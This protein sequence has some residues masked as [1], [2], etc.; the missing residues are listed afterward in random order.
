V[1]CF[2]VQKEIDC[3]PKTN[4]SLSYT[5]V[6]LRRWGLK[7]ETYNE[8]LQQTNFLLPVVVTNFGRNICEALLEDRAVRNKNSIISPFSIHLVMSMLYYG[9]KKPSSTRDQLHNA[10]GSQVDRET[11]TKSAWHY[12]KLLQMYK[13]EKEALGLQTEI[14]N[15]IFVKE[16][17]EVKQL[18]KEVL[19]FYL[20]SSENIDFENP[21]LAASEINQFVSTKTKGLIDKIISPSNIDSLTRL[22]LV[23]AIYFKAGWKYSFDKDLTS[24]MEFTLSNNKVIQHPRGMRVTADFRR[25]SIE[26]LNADVLELPY[27]DPDFKMYI[28]TPQRNE[29][30]SLD[31]IATSINFSK[32]QDILNSSAKDRV[33]V[34]LPAFEISFENDLKRSLKSLGITSIFEPYEAEF[35]EIS[36]KELYVS[37]ILHRAE[38]KVDEEGSEAAAATGVVLGTKSFRP[39]TVHEF[40][41]DRPFVFVIHDTR[42]KIPLF[43]GRVL[44][45]TEKI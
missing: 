33:K 10:L 41:V 45:P 18:F 28:I 13:R 29:L 9:A 30:S 20:T 8:T 36:D 15:K 2:L 14:A 5:N 40:R 44:N 17:F 7:E 22:V 25:G 23:N 39:P 34:T 31:R 27:I 4:H 11:F 6:L 43:I 1:L 35:T 12:L 42:N 3:V 32:I 26:E 24:P 16:G 38:L 37:S 21:S 19:K